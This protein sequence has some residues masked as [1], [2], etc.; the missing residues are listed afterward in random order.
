MKRWLVVLLLPALVYIARLS[1]NA[2]QEKVYGEDRL[3][4]SNETDETVFAAV[5][6][7]PFLAKITKTSKITRASNVLELSPGAN[8]KLKRPSQ[9]I[10]SDRTLLVSQAKNFPTI[11]PSSKALEDAGAT[12]NVGQLQAKRFFIGMEDGKL[13]LYTIGK[14]EQRGK[15]GI[16]PAAQA[17]LSTLLSA[18]KA[19][20][21]RAYRA[22]V[23]EE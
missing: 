9:R 8:L 20:L 21:S 3:T 12:I 10:G 23:P 15:T 6:Y 18:T 7:E 22:I 17:K 2:Q 16:V 5:Y 4:I 19:G 13:K 14:W 11:F 1:I